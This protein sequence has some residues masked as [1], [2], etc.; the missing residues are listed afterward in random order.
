VRMGAKHCHRPW[1]WRED[2]PAK[3]AQLAKRQFLE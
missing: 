3:M 2:I 1:Y